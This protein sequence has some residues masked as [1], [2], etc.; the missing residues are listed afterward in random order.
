MKK[1]L[2]PIILIL[3]IGLFTSCSRQLDL[4]VVNAHQVKSYMPQYIAYYLPKTKLSLEL[5]LT[6]ISEQ[7]GPYADYADEFLG[8]N[9]NIIKHNHTYWQITDIK[10]KT[11]PI[12]DTN[13]LWFITGKTLQAYNVHITQD[14]FL[15][16]INKAPEQQYSLS[17]QEEKFVEQSKY[18]SVTQNLTTVDRG[19]KEVYDTIFHVQEFDTT[20]RVVPV[21]KKRLIKKSPREQAQEI[22][23]EIFTLR[24]DRTALLEG[25]G[26][27]D[28]LPDGQA[29]KVMI[30][31]L[32]KLEK[33]YLSLFVGRVDKTSYHYKYVTVPDI[34]NYLTK[35][36]IFRFSPQYGLLPITDMRGK[37]IY[38]EIET[39]GTTKP[40]KNFIKSQDLLRR[41]EK[42]PYYKGI[43]YRVPEI[44]MVRILLD[45][46]LLAQKQILLPQAG[47]I[48]RLPIDIFRQKNIQVEFDPHTGAILSIDSKQK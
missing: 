17:W 11:T 32:D 28:Y 36:M 38:L 27:S 22:A 16:S 24:D 20:Q 33:Q 45:N 10:I 44:A 23:N 43:A 29:I 47:T 31:G 19:Y 13:N 40:L 48:A 21:I 5:Q 9:E 41:I 4:A 3:S 2:I 34:K 18:K 12:R 14:G 46:K 30:S 7:K 25:E 6:K 8:S 15:A 39:F 1:L 42:L 35:A 37:P 26:D